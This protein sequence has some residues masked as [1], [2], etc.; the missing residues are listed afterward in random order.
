MPSSFTLGPLT[1][2]VWGTLAAL[3]FLLGLHLSL[4]AARRE[5]VPEKLIWDV[6][7][8]ALVGMLL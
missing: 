6:L 8:I 7:S 5:G 2:Q 1:F 3:G 4:R